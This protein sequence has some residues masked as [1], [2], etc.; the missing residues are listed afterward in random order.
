M[1]NN[2]TVRRLENL[3]KELKED[4]TGEVDGVLLAEI[5]DSIIED[6]KK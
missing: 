2:H 6:L 4:S 5:I 3:S 1:Q